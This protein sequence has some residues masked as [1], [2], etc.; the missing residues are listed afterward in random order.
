MIC[1]QMQ[2]EIMISAATACRILLAAAAFNAAT[3]SALKR[4]QVERNS[5]KPSYQLLPHHQTASRTGPPSASQSSCRPAVARRLPGFRRRPAGGYSVQKIVQRYVQ[6][7]AT[8][9]HVDYLLVVQQ[10]HQV[11]LAACNERTWLVNDTTRFMKGAP[12]DARRLQRTYTTISNDTPRYTACT[13]AMVMKAR[14]ER[15]ITAVNQA[16]RD[17][18][19]GRCAPAVPLPV[20]RYSTTARLAA[21]GAIEL[22]RHVRPGTLPKRG[23]QPS[24]GG[25]TS[26]SGRPFI[27]LAELTR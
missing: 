9:W 7:T 3:G 4:W 15:C 24:G 19:A 14:P 25:D 1:N 2:V 12:G 10:A 5:G 6:G 16:W 21:S 13:L 18:D 17:K 20:R 26:N 22:L 23:D 8:A 27:R 11:A